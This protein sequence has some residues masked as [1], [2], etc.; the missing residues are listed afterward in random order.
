VP[1]FHPRG[2]LSVRLTQDRADRRRRPPD[3]EPIQRI[4]F[5]GCVRRCRL[6]RFFKI[7]RCGPHAWLARSR[8][9]GGGA[10][11]PC[12]ALGRLCSCRT[13]PRPFLAHD[14]MTS[15][16]SRLLVCSRY[17]SSIYISRLSSVDLF[18]Y[19]YVSWASSSEH[20]YL[21]VR[22]DT[23]A[24]YAFRPPFLELGLATHARTLC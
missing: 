10:R 1:F 3:R 9:G 2:Y 8:A 11:C 22:Y 4:Q 19:G 17:P 5:V 16:P 24:A 21:T 20:I 15:R 23:C 6:V 18:A 12:C 13:R 14:L 7:R